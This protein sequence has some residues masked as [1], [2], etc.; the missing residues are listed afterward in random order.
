[1]V[2]KSNKESSIEKAQMAEKQRICSTPL[3]S[4]K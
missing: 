3:Q 2:H 1:M 4:E